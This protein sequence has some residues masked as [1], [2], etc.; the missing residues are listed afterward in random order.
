MFISIDA[1]GK[2]VIN[3]V[4]KKFMMMSAQ[5]HIIIDPTKNVGPNLNTKFTSIACRFSS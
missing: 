4:Q 5:K 3:S 2:I 1:F